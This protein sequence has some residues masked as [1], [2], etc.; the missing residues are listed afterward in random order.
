M[1]S[2]EK[3]C[4]GHG[5]GDHQHHPEHNHNHSHSHGCGHQHAVP[6]GAKLG[7]S[8]GITLLV[9]GA[10]LVGGYMT[11]SLAL[12]SD[13]WHVLADA[14]A[15][16]ISWWAIKQAQKSS[17]LANTF[18]F[19]RSQVVAGFINGL[20]L[21]VISGWILIEA[22]QRLF[23]PVPVLGKEMF[24]IATVGLVANLL[25]A[26]L[27]NGHAHDDMN[28]KSAFLHVLGDAL[29]SVGVIVAGVL[30]MKYQWY[31]AD[32]LI[33]IAISL[34]IVRSAYRVTRQA[35]HIL[36]E[37]SP[38]GVDLSQ[39]LQRLSQVPSV[40]GVHDL[41]VWNITEAITCLAVHIEVAAEAEGDA[42]L[43]SCN[44]LL[45]REF[46][47]GHSTIQLERQGY[48]GCSRRQPICTLV[49]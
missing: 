13:A 26:L 1:S 3:S 36:M 49:A 5:Q 11:H 38:V 30:M 48:T 14:L 16:I 21:L 23:N 17:T 45:E 24:I 34:M 10:E 29:A 22:V 39:V 4:C 7:W 41:H 8:V 2:K 35:F 46:H 43:R 19:H 31:L 12:L 37:G 28:V 42:I 25:I 9:F 15:L 40:S 32:P 44:E 6:V 33:S 18:G 20:S 47:I 27:L